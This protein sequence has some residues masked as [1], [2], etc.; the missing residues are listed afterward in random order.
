MMIVV[1]FVEIIVLIFHNHYLL[2]LL[3]HHDQY[4]LV[5]I[6]YQ[7]IMMMVLVENK[8]DELDKNIVKDKQIHKIS[9]LVDNKWVLFDLELLYKQVRVLEF[10]QMFHLFH[11]DWL[12]WGLE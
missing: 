6:Y 2:L 3:H 8:R 9:C 12:W 11:P 5:E 10:V 7:L 4:H 1:L